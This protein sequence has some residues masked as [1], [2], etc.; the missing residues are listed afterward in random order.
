MLSLI[1]PTYRERD[2]IEVLLRQIA[3]V[4]PQIEEDFEILI[5]DSLSEDQTADCARKIVGHNLPGRVIDYPIKDLTQSILEGIR[6]AKGNLIGIMDADCSHPPELL[7]VLVKAVY[8]GSALAIASRYVQG[9]RIVGWPWTRRLLSRLG[10]ALVR[11]ISP[12]KDPTSGFFVCHADVMRRLKSRPQG[13]KILLELLAQDNVQPIREI[14][15]VF[16]DRRRGKSKL[17]LGVLAHYLVQLAYLYGSRLRPA[18]YG[19]PRA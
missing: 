8:G 10:C 19:A 5:V 17:R 2:N 12:V 4:V 14:P 9:G 7:P 16:T 6:Q 15:Y 3:T 11:P 1:I 18:R 13:F